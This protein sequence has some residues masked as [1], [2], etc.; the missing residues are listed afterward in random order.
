MRPEPE[1]QAPWPTALVWWVIWLGLLAGFLQVW[2]FSWRL[3]PRA[4]A[5]AAG[6]AV[7]LVAAGC[8]ILSAAIRWL[9]LPRIGRARVAFIFFLAGLALAETGGY[10]G[11]FLG[12]GHRGILAAGGLLGLLQF[13]PRFARRYSAPPAARRPAPAAGRRR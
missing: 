11:I 13:L 3:P 4:I 10:G 8:L 9:L 5:P 7:W 12:G 6:I 2:N 1:R